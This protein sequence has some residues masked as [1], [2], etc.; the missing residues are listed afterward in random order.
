M[1]RLE[2][3]R[4]EAR[5]DESAQAI[6]HWRRAAER[7]AMDRSQHHSIHHMI[8]KERGAVSTWLGSSGWIRERAG[9]EGG[10][11]RGVSLQ[12]KA[13][14]SGT[15]FIVASLS[16]DVVSCVVVGIRRCWSWASCS[17]NCPPSYSNSNSNKHD[18]QRGTHTYKAPTDPSPLGCAQLLLS[19]RS[20]MLT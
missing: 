3:A 16:C 2:A 19:D 18:K 4:A 14:A 11:N 8:H 15:E 5:V 20:R 13:G 17:V 12:V 7:H 10:V 6:T 9:A 1:C